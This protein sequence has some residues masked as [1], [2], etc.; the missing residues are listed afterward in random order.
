MFSTIKRRLVFD[1]DKL[2]TYMLSDSFFVSFMISAA[3][4]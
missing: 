1:V 3:G 2:E 4:T